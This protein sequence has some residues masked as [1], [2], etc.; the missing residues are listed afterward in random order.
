M[1]PLLHSSHD[2]TSRRLRAERMSGEVSSCCAS[3]SSLIGLGEP[4]GDPPDFA[5]AAEVCVVQKCVST[6][7]VHAHWHEH[8]F[9]PA[10][11]RLFR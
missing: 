3:L 5:N 7:G 6:S 9:S 4:R 11:N 2:W 8:L 1:S 10:P